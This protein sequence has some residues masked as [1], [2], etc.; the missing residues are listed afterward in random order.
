MPPAVVFREF[1]VA[2]AQVLGSPEVRVKVVSF[3]QPKRSV[4]FSPGET[5]RNDGLAQAFPAVSRPDKRQYLAR[6]V[7]LVIADSFPGVAQPAGEGCELLLKEG[8]F[9][10]FAQERRQ[11]IR[12]GRSVAL[13]GP[14]NSRPPSR[15]DANAAFLPKPRRPAA[16]RAG[17]VDPVLCLDAVQDNFAGR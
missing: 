13:F 3:Y 14:N 11:E 12:Q 6:E 16:N 9:A 15:Q 7:L 17:V 8:V 4:S 5:L 10:A 2:E 1:F